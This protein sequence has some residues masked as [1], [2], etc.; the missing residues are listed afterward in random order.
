MQPTSIFSESFFTLTVEVFDTYI[1][2]VSKV[3][4]L[5]TSH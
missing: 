4:I 2:D 5:L 1:L 3:V